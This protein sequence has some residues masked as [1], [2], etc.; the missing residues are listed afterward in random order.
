[1]AKDPIVDEVRRIRAEQAAEYSYDLKAILVA[2]RKR[3]QR[4]G[5][6]VVSYASKKKIGA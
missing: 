6:K 5:K 1:M 3:Q 2:A 4:S